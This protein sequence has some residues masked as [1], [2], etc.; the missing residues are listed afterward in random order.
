VTATNGFGT[1]SATSAQTA[2]VQAAA[3]SPAN[4]S[5]PAITGTPQV[6][7]TLT[8]STGTWTGSQPI[9]YAYQWRRCGVG[10]SSSILADA[11]LSYW[12]LG[13]SSGTTAA[14][15]RGVAPGTYQNGITLG[16][17]GAL[18]GDA[19]TSVSLDGVDDAVSFANPNLSGPFSI[20]LW[21]FLAG[22]GSS[23]ALGYATLVGYDY[24]HRLL[25]QTYGSNQL[26]AQFDG[27][28]FSSTPVSANAWHHIVYSFDGTSERFYVD[29][30]AA[31]VHA[32]T[33]PV[34]NQPFRL[35]SFDA[36]PHYKL[37][38]VLDEVAL[39]GRALSAAEVQAHYANR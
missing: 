9:S 37:N 6:G 33:L 14:D 38:G 34:W 10:Y 24:T 18:T 22:P 11:P 7:Q 15:E 32:T 2:A 20:E 30:Q 21:A 23:G 16:A 12:R 3:S 17:A 35:G 39:Y 25:W 28:F 29:G 26:L 8:A 1:A 31:G 4:T 27:N 19:N 13:E 5:P 36:G